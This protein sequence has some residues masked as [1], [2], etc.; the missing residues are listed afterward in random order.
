VLLPDNF[1]DFVTSSVDSLSFIS[2]MLTCFL[3]QKLFSAVHHLGFTTSAAQ[4]GLVVPPVQHH[5][6]ANS[7]ALL[8]PSSLKEHVK[9][10]TSLLDTSGGRK[11]YAEFRKDRSNTT[12]HVVQ[13]HTDVKIL[14]GQQVISYS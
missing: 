3:L 13:N 14:T 7:L 2:L 6:W 8:F 10:V 11:G 12:T 5:R 4:S 1:C 9:I